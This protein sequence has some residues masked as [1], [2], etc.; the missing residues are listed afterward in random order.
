[1]NEVL[2]KA[3]FDEIYEEKTN[4]DINKIKNI[5]KSGININAVDENGYNY[6]IAEIMR[7]NY[8]LYL[9]INK[10][11]CSESY[12]IKNQVFKDNLPNLD[13]S[14]IKLLLEYGIDVNYK[15]PDE[16]SAL[17]NALYVPAPELIELLLKYGA[18]PNYINEDNENILDVAYMELFY[19]E[20]LMGNDFG[21]RNIETIIEILI[22]YGAK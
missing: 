20:R 16:D 7:L 13:F 19:Y 11:E 18:N 5:L 4:P 10:N 14:I 8:N 22:K 6:L 15:V 21:K 17:Y 9:Q 12:E 3:L 2:E 1:M